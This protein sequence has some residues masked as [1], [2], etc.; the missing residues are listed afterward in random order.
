[1]KISH[2]E[3]ETKKLYIQKEDLLIIKE[4]YET[5]P[6]FI[7]NS[8]KENINDSDFIEIINEGQIRYINLIKWII[9]FDKYKNITTDEYN[10]LYQDYLKKLSRIVQEISLGINTNDNIVMKHIITK[11]IKD[12]YAIYQNKYTDN[13]IILPI[14]ASQKIIKR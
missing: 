5:V 12:I 10:K 13:K 14:K 4:E 6:D 9:D 3:N 8:V 1:M 7:E 11:E 2:T